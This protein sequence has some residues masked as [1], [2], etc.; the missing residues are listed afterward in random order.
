VTAKERLRFLPKK[1]TYV[2]SILA[3]VV[4]YAFS[5]R[6]LRI[7]DGLPYLH[8]W[9]EP[10]VVSVALN[11]L[12]TGDWNPHRFSYGGFT[13]YSCVAVDVLHYYYLMGKDKGDF[14][15]LT[16][17]DEIETGKDTGWNW[18]VS[19]P[20]FYLWNRAFIC[21]LGTLGVLVT[22]LIGREIYND[23]AGVCAASLV[24]ALP[25]CI[26]HSILVSP[27]MSVCV[28][29]LLVVLFALRFNRTHELKDLVWSSLCVGLATSSKYNAFL[30]IIVPLIAYGLNFRVVKFSSSVGLPLLIG[31]PL[32]V[33]VILNPFALVDF[34][35]FL[36]HSGAE[37]RH[38]KIVG[39]GSATSVPGLEHVA[40]QA[41][42]IR[43]KLSSVFF[44]LAFVGVVACLRKP[45]LLLI[46][47]AFPVLYLL[48]MTR[49]KVNFHRNYLV[50][51][52]FLAAFTGVAIAFLSDKLYTST[53]FL[54]VKFLRKLNPVCRVLS[55]FPVVAFI[56]LLYPNYVNEFAKARRIWNT[57]E[58]RTQAI[59]CINRLLEEKNPSKAKIGI[60][61]ELR[62]HR[63]D[64]KKLR[65]DYELFTHKDIK[66][67]LK[68]YNYLLVGTFRSS[69]KRMHAEDARLNRLTP[70]HLTVHT[71]RGGPLR[72]DIYSIHPKV[73]ILKSRSVPDR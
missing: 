56:V 2:Y 28:F 64:L 16:G 47:L 3:L 24:A 67:A 43:E 68:K 44:Y 46:S 53:T 59:G 20:S 57:S 13:V 22:F 61:K 54:K 63:L 69:R 60:A 15:Y 32:V 62:I 38:Y 52:P 34:R 30:C 48:F 45:R 5:V 12:K 49:Q 70:K 9:D 51:Y 19:H 10:Y 55:V 11:M 65:A 31:L 73:L 25:F 4:L 26:G 23:L 8:R 39:H 35:T 42:R 66:S 36:M 1:Q 21:I 71:V 27:N 40:L 18:T 41:S 50:V 6:F 17:L 14:D 58:T 33:F 72:R 37:V 29:V 7:R